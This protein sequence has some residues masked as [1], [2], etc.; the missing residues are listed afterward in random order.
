MNYILNT[1]ETFVKRRKINNACQVKRKKK[2]SKA[3]LS[4]KHHVFLNQQLLNLDKEGYF[5]WDWKS[6][7]LVED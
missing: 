3:Q 5:S 7:T 6:M 2:S 4:R 1:E